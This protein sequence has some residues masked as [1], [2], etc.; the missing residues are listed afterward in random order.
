MYLRPLYFLTVLLSVAACGERIT[1]EPPVDL[2]EEQRNYFPLAIGREWVYQVDSV[3]FDYGASGVTLRDS[4]ATLVLERVSDTLRDNTGALVWQIER[5]ERANEVEP[6]HLK[7]IFTSE[8]NT[9]QAIRTEQNLR[10]LKLV[11]PLNRRSEWDG[12]IWIDENREIE[13]ADERM[14]PYVG[15]NYEVD[16]IDVAL[17][18]GAFSYDSTL[19]VTEVDE[20]NIIERRLSKVIYAKHVGQ[21]WREQWILDS[22]YCNQSPVPVDCETKP[23]EEK[24]ERGYIIRQLLID[25]R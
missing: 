17:Q 14:R 20:T 10:F 7:H 4:S 16:S 11:F 24:A 13:I 12:N 3:V 23:W 6:W 25:Y 9:S 1:A 21:V 8:Q 18:V 2:S 15:W 19:V 5:Y 22:Q